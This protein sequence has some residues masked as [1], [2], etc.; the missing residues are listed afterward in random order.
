MVTVIEGPEMI[1]SDFS[2]RKVARSLI[3]LVL[4]FKFRATMTLES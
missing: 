3:L 2:F 1:F 4:T